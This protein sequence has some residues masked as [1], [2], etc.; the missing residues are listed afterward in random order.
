MIPPCPLLP[1]AGPEISAVSMRTAGADRGPAFYHLALVCA[2]ALWQKGLPAQSILMLNRAFSSALSPDD[3][4]LR[5]WPPPYAALDW[6]LRHRWE[7][8]F[9][10]NP[11]RHFQHLAT[12]MSGPRH[13]VRIWR[14][15]ACWAISCRALPWA[16]ADTKQI[17]EEGIE[18]P[19]LTAISER[20]RQ[21]GWEGEAEIW[22]RTMQ[23]S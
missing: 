1:P 13:E 12:R 21:L 22:E 7:D 3:P 4:I 18:E 17:A 2:Q 16:E 19:G 11:R 6:V 5:E 15:W 9:V 14:A 20:L 8:Q 10:G 23:I